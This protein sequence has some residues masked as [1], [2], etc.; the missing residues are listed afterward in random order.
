MSTYSV[1]CTIIRLRVHNTCAGMSHKMFTV[2]DQ[3]KLSGRLIGPAGPAYTQGMNHQMRIKRKLAEVK[4]LCGKIE[5]DILEKQNR[6]WRS[7]QRE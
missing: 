1:Q 7:E 4:P 6:K 2:D 5:G 3:H